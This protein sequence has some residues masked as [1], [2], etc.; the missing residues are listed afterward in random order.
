MQR[1]KYSVMFQRVY[2]NTVETKQRTENIEGLSQDKCKKEEMVCSCNTERNNISSPFHRSSRQELFCKKAALKN[3]VKFTEKHLHQ[4][5]LFN[6]VA[7]LRPTT[8]LKRDLWYSC[9]PV[10]FTK[11]LRTPFSI[12]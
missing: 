1:I 2:L 7:G 3:F 12:E 6:K 10:N 9:F 11:C 5:L 8:L 4:S